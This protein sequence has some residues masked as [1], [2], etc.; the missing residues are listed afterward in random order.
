MNLPEMCVKRP[1]TATMVWMAALVMG[2]VALVN[3]PVELMPNMAP[4]QVSVIVR[5]RGGMPPSEVESLVTRPVEEAVSTVSN[6]REMVST[7]RKGESWVMLEFMPGVN[8]ELAALEVREKLAPIKE[9][10]PREIEKPVI[11]R[12]SQSDQPVMLLALTSLEHTPEE[13]RRIVDEKFKEVIMRVEGVANVDVYG[14]QERKILVELDQDRLEGYRLS[15]DRVMGMLGVNNL[16]LLAG[17]VDRQHSKYTIRT[18]GEFEDIEA[19]RN[20]GVAVSPDGAII[21]LRDVAVVSDSFL[22]PESLARVN[23]QPVVSIYCFKESTANTINVCEGIRQETDRLMQK[24]DPNISLKTILDQS[25][26]ITKAIDSVKTSLW[27][28]GLIAVAVLFLFLRDYRPTL[29]VTTTLPCSITL[30]FMLMYLSRLA[31][32]DMTLNVMTLSGLALGIGNLM[33]N[34]IVVL[35]NTYQKRDKGLPPKESAIEGA[36]EV[37][38]AVAASTLTT[39]VV[40]LPFVF[41]SEDVRR[42]WSGLA[43][44]IT[45]AQVV[46]LLVGITLVPMLATRLPVRASSASQ[47]TRRPNRVMRIYRRALVACVRYRYLLLLVI[48]T[49]LVF[50]CYWLS[51]R[52]EKEFMPSASEGQFTI[53][54]ELEPGAKLGV[55]DLAVKDVEQILGRYPEIQSFSSRIETSS[56]KVYVTLAPLAQRKLS[57]QQIIDSL[58]TEL[59]IIDQKY[60]GGFTYFSEVKEK[61]MREIEL[62]IYGYDYTTLKELASSIAS[63]LGGVEGFQDIRMSRIEGRPEWGVKVD[64]DRA[65][66]MGLDVADV[67][68]TLHAQM[69]GMRATKF[70]DKE[71]EVEVIVRLQKRFW[72]TLDDLRKL[73]V[74]NEEG[75]SA[76][77]ERVSSFV[78]SVV[79]AE[80]IRKNKSRLIHVTV[81]STKLGTEKAIAAIRQALAD[82]QFPKEYYWRVGGN[83]YRNLEQQVQLRWVL[84]L[85]LVLV[86]MV[87]ASLFESFLQPWLI[88]TA[89][90]LALI[91]VTGALAMTHEPISRGVLLGLIMLAGI[92]VNNSIVLLD[93]I[94]LLRSQGVARLRS[95]ITAGA[96]RLRPILMTA[97]T[98]VLG[99]VPMAFDRSESA[100]LWAPMAITA[101]GGLTA[102]TVL[103]LL[104]FPSL[105]VILDDLIVLPGAIKTWIVRRGDALGQLV[106][107][108][109]LSPARQAS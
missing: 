31:G 83:Y 58:R 57:T 15:I 18:I 81:N 102:S 65:A 45:F 93:H 74:V 109:W 46:S 4:S 52:T 82:V 5:I 62:D 106:R 26:A 14:G 38:L 75:E 71:A 53:F 97:S 78:P 43:L 105:T 29:I 39:I 10:L 107:L 108:R 73:V 54:V 99:L 101:I 76:S 72:D 94:N 50:S 22:E 85:T 69:R 84:V 79:P 100:S 24:I 77:F 56:S 103:I 21:R 2:V 7:S 17:E 80:V 55:S 28:G 44:T 35:E 48:G 47:G 66:E 96:D 20:M 98:T 61:G 30:T 42:L 36:A 32:Q 3:L 70:Y 64:R 67:A 25:V 90:P 68:E 23:V 51:V 60:K 95:V 6:L 1:V 9:N 41:V 49:L 40:F 91:G 16:N 92:V 13:L 37:M 59:K 11:A 34:A 89:V 33:D 19:I 8:T 63:R 27:Q 12:Y 86:F 104:V 87:L 88:L